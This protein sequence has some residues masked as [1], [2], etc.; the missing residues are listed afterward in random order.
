VS[1]NPNIRP[2]F[3]HWCSHADNREGAPINEF[4]PDII[5]CR[6]YTSTDFFAAQDAVSIQLDL[7]RGAAE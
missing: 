1:A 5:Y 4:D 6:C 3:Q 2:R 7:E